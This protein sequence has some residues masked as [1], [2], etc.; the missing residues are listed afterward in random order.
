[1]EISCKEFEKLIPDFI[2]NK[3]D[4]SMLE[5]FCEHR[6]NCGECNEEL[7]IQYLVAKG[8][9]RLEEGDTFDLQNELENYLT[10]IDYRL[11]K[12]KRFIKIEKII[13]CV[14]AFVIIC[15]II[16]MMN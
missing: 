2:D 13:E 16:W 6:L 1:M 15:G 8:I 3:L 7:E 4:R 9:T 14:V 10:E 12:Y 5:S 11:N